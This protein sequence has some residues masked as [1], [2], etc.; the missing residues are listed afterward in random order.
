MTPTNLPHRDQI[1]QSLER[2][3]TDYIDVYLLHNPEYYLLK[4]VTT[5]SSE[6]QAA[7]HRQRMFERI[8]SAFEELEHETGRGRIRS[9]GISSNSF[10]LKE[11]DPFFLPYEGLLE[12]AAQAAQAAGNMTHSFSTV[13][14]PANILE[15]EGL[16]GCGQ[17]AHDHGLRVLV[18][19]PLN[20]FTA[21]GSFRYHHRNSCAKAVP[22]R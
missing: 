11:T 22:S 5:E 4:N 17:W 19:R 21:Q 16:K 1:A 13:Q 7:L 8:K 9:Y 10:S 3:G 6:A 12:L 15:Q 2:L 20:A 18:N 14:F